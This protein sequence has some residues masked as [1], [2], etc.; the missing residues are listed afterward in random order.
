MSRADGK[1]GPGVQM[2]VCVSKIEVWPAPWGPPFAPVARTVPSGRNTAGPTSYEALSALGY[3]S[4]S[5][6]TV[7][8]ALLHVPLRGS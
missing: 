2:P 8:P 5:W 7:L 1:S 3:E 6:T 4:Q